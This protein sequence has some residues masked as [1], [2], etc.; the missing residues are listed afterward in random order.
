M[1]HI[2]II[3][4]GVIGTGWTARLLANG[5]NV[6]AWDPSDNFDSRLIANIKRLWPTLE[7]YGVTSNA[8]LSNLSTVNS[9][10]A[11]CSGAILVQESVPEDLAIKKHLHRKISEAT[12]GSTIVA[13]SSSG[14]LPTEIQVV[15]EDPER[16]IIGHPFNPVYLLPLIEIVG[17]EKT[18][19][20][21]IESAK[22][23]YTSIGMYPLVVRKEIEGYLAD[24]LQEAQW[25]EILHLVND[26]VA[27]TEE[28]DDAIIY[29]PG[30]R[31]AMMGTCLTFHLAGGNSGMRHMLKQFGPSLKLPWTK[32]EAPELTDSLIDKMVDG[33]LLQAG[34]KS[35]EEL[36]E[37][38][39]SCLIEIIQALKKFQIGAG[40]LR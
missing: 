29:G 28:I 6:K 12:S 2:A 26:D 3:G 4:T 18:S 37:L 33:T 21:T 1:T 30:L 31:W 5:H 22:N 15:Y 9:L 19:Q 40:K 20:Q 16:F 35:I 14:L 32:L 36:E 17:G 27:T 11:A 38:R 34:D 24:R 23:F 13:S 7:K 8:S 25:R 10:D 39:D